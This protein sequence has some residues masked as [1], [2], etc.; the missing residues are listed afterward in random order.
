M[1]SRVD[2]GRMRGNRF[3]QFGC[4]FQGHPLTIT[5]LPRNFGP[6]PVIRAGLRNGY[7][8]PPDRLTAT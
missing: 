8:G 3:N 1:V 4:S 6:W 2:F 7:A 5:L